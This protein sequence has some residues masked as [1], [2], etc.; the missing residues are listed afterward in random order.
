MELCLHPELVSW[1]DRESSRLVTL[2]QDLTELEQASRPV[3]QSGDERARVTIPA[4]DIIGEIKH[5]QVDVAGKMVTRFFP[6]DGRVLGLTD[7]RLVEASTVA[8]KISVR[9]ELVNI[10]SP[11]TIQEMLLDWIGDKVRNRPVEPLTIKIAE[12]VR[13][14]AKPISIWIPIDDTS[15]ESDLPFADAVLTN[16]SRRE[17]DAV[18]G[19]A[20]KRV[21]KPDLERMREKLHREWLGK[22][23]MRFQF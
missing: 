8:E 20:G 10:L 12:V 1:I 19:E 16:V 17:L 13:D 4:E 22:A 11:F 18:I 21:A 6:H 5:S 9:R 15:V 2:V 7:N 14:R 23:M 3:S